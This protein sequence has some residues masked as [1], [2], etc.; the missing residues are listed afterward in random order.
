MNPA[1]QNLVISLGAMQLAKKVPFDDP[2][3]LTYVRIAYVATQVIVLG[4]YFYVGQQIKKKNDQTVLKYVEPSP[5]DSNG[6]K[7]VTTTIRDYDLQ[8]TSKLMRAVYFGLA[9]MSFMH[10]Y[11]KYTQPL[12]IQALMGVKTLYDAK[13]VAIYVFG[14]PAEGDLKRPFKQG[15]MFGA[16]ADPQTDKAAIDEAEKKVGKK[17]D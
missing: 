11:L 8:E 1:V 7:L 2:Q 9:M 3:V 13:P 12:F 6:G 4:V 14:K 15:G 10:L 17:E 16:A 5:M